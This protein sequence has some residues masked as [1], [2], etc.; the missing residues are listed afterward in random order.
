MN[1]KIINVL[2]LLLLVGSLA[3]AGGKSETTKEEPAATS[4]TAAK[5]KYG[6]APMLAE[7]VKAGKLPPVDERLPENPRVV[8]PVERVGK[9]G[10]TWRQGMR[11]IADWGLVDRQS[12]HKE[13]LVV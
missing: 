11:T 3:F 2:L 4:T 7:L 1:K 8:Q 13:G 10:G 9:Y 6:E 5:G 12:T